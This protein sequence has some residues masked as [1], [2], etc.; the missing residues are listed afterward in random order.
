MVYSLAEDVD[1]KVEDR[2]TMLPEQ[3]QEITEHTPWPKPLAP[4]RRPQTLEVA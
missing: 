4:A 3:G 2:P 1:T